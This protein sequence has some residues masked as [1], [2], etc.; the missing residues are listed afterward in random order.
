[1]VEVAAAIEIAVTQIVAIN[2][3]SAVGDVGVV[4][5]NH[6]TTMPVV[7]PVPPAP[8]ESSEETNS[9]SDTEIE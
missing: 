1:M 8:S 3:R 4:V 9:K 5:V 2:D 7:S 6:T